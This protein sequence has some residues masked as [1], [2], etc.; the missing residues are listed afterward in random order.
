VFHQLEPITARFFFKKQEKKPFH[1]KMASFDHS[2]FASAF[3]SYGASSGRQSYGGWNSG[4]GFGKGKGK[5]R[6][7]MEQQLNS[8]NWS[9]QQLVPFEK[10]FYMEHPRV[11]GRSQEEVDEIRAK[12]NITITTGKAMN[13]VT[14]FEEASFP[15]YVLDAIKRAGFQT[16]SPIQVQG[17]PVAL[18]GRD[19][20]GVAETGSGKTCAFLLPAIVHINAQPMLQSGD[21]PIV[22]AMA[23]TRELAVQIKEQCDKFGSSSNIKNTC[24]YGGAPKGPQARDL[25]HGVEICIA[26]PG[27]LI[28]FISTGTTNLKRVTYLVLDE[29]DRM[30]DMG[31]EP[32]I[33]KITSQIRP[34]R[35]TLLWSATWPREIQ[36][37][38]RDLCREDPVQINIGSEDLKAN[39]RIKQYVEVLEPYKKMDRLN[40]LM[41]RIMDGN[42]K[43]LIFAET[44]RNCDNLCRDLRMAG[45]PALAIHGDK[46]QSE[47]DWVLNEFKSG[48]APVMIAT[49]VA[50]RG[51][52][53]KD[54]KFVVNFDF[55]NN[56]E[57]YVHRIGRTGRAG[58]TGVSYTFFTA[59]K[60]KHARELVS[61]MRDA[62]QEVPEELERLAGGRGG[63]RW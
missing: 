49:D 28:D 14:T 40:A 4:K 56:V 61:I 16:P 27:R 51:L 21:G 11:A 38:A 8:I 7:G 20:I 22:L 23:P 5:G 31:F 52:D 33:R 41:E 50:S 18:S 44:K 37:L 47:R 34:D 45:Y 30:L 55:P 19:L 17:W 59:D 35:Q 58:A 15:D 25:R 12:L 60:Y 43:I 13:P 6:G 53:V 1:L 3:G 39:K 36:K 48:A 46:E 24:V 2:N 62:D 57:D 32:Q 10:N 9:E 29:A 54:V 26:T 63:R 42:S